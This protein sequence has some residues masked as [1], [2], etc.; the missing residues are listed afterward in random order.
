MLLIRGSFLLDSWI[1]NVL[2]E[3]LAA[4]KQ[5]HQQARERFR[6]V[7]GR[8]RE[9]LP[10][11]RAGIPGS[12]GNQMA[13]RAAAEETHARREHLEALI[14]LNEYRIRGTVPEHLKQRGDPRKN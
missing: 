7:M 3:E 5:R 1:L 8:P 6:N 2:K 4:A 12:D 9:L 10:R 11:D 13:R 14:R